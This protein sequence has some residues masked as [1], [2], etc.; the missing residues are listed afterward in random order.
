MIDVFQV[1][2]FAARLASSPSPAVEGDWRVE[3]SQKVAEEWRNNVPVDTGEYRESIHTTAEGAVAEVD[4]AGYVEY[5]TV[6]TPP[7]PALLPA[8]TRLTRPA[9]EDAVRRVLRS[10]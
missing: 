3:W 2:R 9:S 8:I 7:Q 10:L 6:D 5:G 1:E 4:Y